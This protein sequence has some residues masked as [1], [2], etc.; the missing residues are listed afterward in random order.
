MA[1]IKS[2][3]KRNRQR[4]KAEAANRIVRGSARTAIKKARTA[5]AAGAPD[6]AELVR[7]AERA[8]DKAAAKGVIHNNNA[9]RRKSR[10]YLAL[11]K[12]A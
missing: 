8:L 2:A 3:E 5:I 7:Q 4:L 12:A 10:L 9:S 11:N 6:A 1:N